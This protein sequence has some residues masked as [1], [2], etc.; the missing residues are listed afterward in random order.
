MTENEFI[1]SHIALEKGMIKA[2][3]HIRN[4]CNSS[5]KAHKEELSKKR[6]IELVNMN[7]HLFTVSKAT[8]YD[9]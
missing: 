3:I 9:K 6:I 2:W 4:L 8:K 5:I 7:K 1:L